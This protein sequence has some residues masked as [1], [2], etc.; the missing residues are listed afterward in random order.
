MAGLQYGADAQIGR[1]YLQR[2]HNAFDLFIEDTAGEVAYLRIANNAIAGFGNLRHV[3]ALHGRNNVV[4][5]AKKYV[6]VNGRKAVFIID[7]DCDLLR[8]AAA[9]AH[10]V[11]LPVYCLENLLLES[12]ALANLL[13]DLSDGTL[14]DAE[15]DREHILRL[16][17][18]AG[19]LLIQ[20]FVWVGTY[21]DRGGKQKAVDLDVS[22]LT[23]RHPDQVVLSTRKVATRRRKLKYDL[24]KAH[25][26]HSLRSRAREIAA[27]VRMSGSPAWHFVSGKHCLFPLVLDYLRKHHDYRETDRQLL[28]RLSGH[29]K[30]VY[31]SELAEVLRNAAR[32]SEA[33][34]KAGSE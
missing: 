10:V 32:V 26:C 9:P 21:L 23:D 24:L 27:N 28:N 6:P 13:V 7:G 8:G 12:E 15:I 20:L 2:T 19:D 22:T 29:C 16:L 33:E 11:R 17:E 30:L 25:S 31:A 1:A 5:Q 14:A 4:Q 3:Y 18:G 34:A